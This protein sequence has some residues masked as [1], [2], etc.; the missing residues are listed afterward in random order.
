ML[1]IRSI[2]KIICKKHLSKIYSYYLFKKTNF[3]FVY[4][5][6]LGLPGNMKI[7]TMKDERLKRMYK[8]LYISNAWLLYGVRVM[9]F[10]S[11]KPRCNPELWIRVRIFFRTLIK[12][13]YFSK[14]LL[15]RNILIFLLDFEKLQIFRSGQHIFFFFW[16]LYADTDLVNLRSGSV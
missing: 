12:L 13:R 14:W 10:W 8:L 5:M 11:T 4:T 1:E 9:H 6:K 3:M 15:K 2:L 16:C 7:F